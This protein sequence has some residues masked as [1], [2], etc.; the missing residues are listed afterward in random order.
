EGGRVREKGRGLEE[1]RGTGRGAG[2]R[3][4]QGDP[5]VTDDFDKLLG[6]FDE[7][8]AERSPA[9]AK[10]AM[11]LASEPAASPK[12][13]T[14][15]PWIVVGVVALL[16]IGAGVTFAVMNLGDSDAT[17]PA[18]SQEPRPSEAPAETPSAEPPSPQPPPPAL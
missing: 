16:A 8:E 17:A 2:S 4:R 9:A 15:L 12:R 7:Q 18:A 3:R 10:K 5:P 13:N 14:V 6:G 1:R 11:P